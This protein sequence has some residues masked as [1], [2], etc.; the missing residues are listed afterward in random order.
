M[1]RSL[2]TQFFAP[3]FVSLHWKIPVLI[4]VCLLYFRWFTDTNED[5]TKAKCVVHM[6][7]TLT[8]KCAHCDDVEISLAY[9]YLILYP[10]YS[11]AKSTVHYTT[12]LSEFHV[13]INAHSFPGGRFHWFFSNQGVFRITVVN[14]V[15]KELDCTESI[16]LEIC[17]P[18]IRTINSDIMTLDE[19]I[20]NMYIFSKWIDGWEDTMAGV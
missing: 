11:F 17:S 16:A 3:Y 10:K 15:I 20:I 18:Q 9:G 5:K 7:V 4:E 8:I 6:H 14:I 12:I 2:A 19:G 13:N 1:K